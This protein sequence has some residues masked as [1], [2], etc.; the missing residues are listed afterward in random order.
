MSTRQTSVQSSEPVHGSLASKGCCL[1]YALTI[2]V[3]PWSKD[4]NWHKRQQW[5]AEGGCSS[6]VADYSM[7][8]LKRPLVLGILGILTW[9]PGALACALIWWTAWNKRGTDFRVRQRDTASCL[10]FVCLENTRS[11]LPRRSFRVIHPTGFSPSSSRL[12]A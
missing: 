12:I 5:P 4:A 10:H 2:Q 7:F 6:M 1:F 11:S 3:S 9:S 8:H